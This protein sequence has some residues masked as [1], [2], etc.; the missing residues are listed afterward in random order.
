MV[1]FEV[2]DDGRRRLITQKGLLETDYFPL[3]ESLDVSET[4]PLDPE[5]MYR[6][7]E[8]ALGKLYE[9]VRNEREQGIYNFHGL[10]IVVADVARNNGRLPL[11]KP[12]WPAEG[13]LT[14]PSPGTIVNK[15]IGDSETLADILYQISTG[16]YNGGDYHDGAIVLD[17]YTQTILGCGVVLLPW[18]FK[19]VEGDIEEEEEVNRV[20]RDGNGSNDGTRRS[21]AQ[22]YSLWE[23]VDRIYTMSEKGSVTCYEGGKSR[24]LFPNFQDPSP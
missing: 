18:I 15:E 23:H 3:F 22:D 7:I 9:R 1:E 21:S 13:S 5:K 12:L 2:T 16:N 19:E 4:S 24:Q 10:M 20:R 11:S 14:S 8:E 17:K 6:T